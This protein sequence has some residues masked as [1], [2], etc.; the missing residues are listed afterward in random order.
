MG[1]NVCM[2]CKQEAGYKGEVLQ[3]TWIEINPWE[4]STYICLNCFDKLGELLADHDKLQEVI[5]NGK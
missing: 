2:I 5:C 4:L 3:S 1:I